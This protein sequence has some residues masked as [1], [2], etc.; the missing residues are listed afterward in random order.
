MLVQG[1]VKLLFQPAEEGGAGGDLLV[2]EGMSLLLLP[3]LVPLAAAAHDGE[4]D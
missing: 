3:L 1:T 4:L 2:Q